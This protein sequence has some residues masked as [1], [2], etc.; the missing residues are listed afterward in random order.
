MH[1]SNRNNIDFT[2]KRSKSSEKDDH[3]LHKVPSRETYE[4]QSSLL[5]GYGEGDGRSISRTSL[6]TLGVPVVNLEILR[7]MEYKICRQ[8]FSKARNG[9]VS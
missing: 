8:E 5:W 9:S 1:G 2:P 4:Y 3:I 6:F 7:P